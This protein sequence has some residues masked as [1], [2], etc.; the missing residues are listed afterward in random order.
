MQYLI[1]SSEERNKEI[2]ECLITLIDF[3]QTI[4]LTIFTILIFHR[5]LKYDM[6]VYSKQDAIHLTLNKKHASKS[7][8]KSTTTNLSQSRCCYVMC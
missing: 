7:D 8:Q 2:R 1:D 3:W 5:Y 4:V 6:N